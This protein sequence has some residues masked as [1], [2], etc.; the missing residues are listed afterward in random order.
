MPWRTSL[1]FSTTTNTNHIIHQNIWS[2]QRHDY[3][4]FVINEVVNAHHIIILINIIYD[5]HLLN[6]IM[7]LNGSH[8][9]GLEKGFSS[10]VQHSSQVLNSFLW[11]PSLH[12]VLSKV[13]YISLYLI[14]DVFTTHFTDSH[15][16]ES[17]FLLLGKE[18]SIPKERRKISQNAS[19]MSHLDPLTH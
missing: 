9:E 1:F 2:F 13:I 8:L 11:F 10:F 19:T 5:F 17:V 15:F 12:Y 14:G 16:N 18:K 7:R 4:I 6:I 3:L